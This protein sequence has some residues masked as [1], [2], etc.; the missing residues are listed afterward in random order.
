MVFDRYSMFEWIIKIYRP[1]LAGINIASYLTLTF[2]MSKCFS[3]LKYEL[4]L[5]YKVFMSP[6]ADWSSPTDEIFAANWSKFLSI[7]IN[8]KWLDASPALSIA[9]C[10]PA[11]ISVIWD[12]DQKH[13]AKSTKERLPDEPPTKTSLYHKT[14]S[15]C[16]HQLIIDSA[17]P[18]EIISNF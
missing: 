9:W 10:T 18:K 16:S 2:Q 17:L 1:G 13:S 4:L 8:G 7:F 11:P 6:T 5:F 15:L 12:N 14:Q 3:A